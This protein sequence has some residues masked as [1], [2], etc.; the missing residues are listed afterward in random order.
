MKIIYKTR[1][2]FQLL[3]FNG[4]NLGEVKPS[5]P[6]TH[7]ECNWYRE[8]SYLN[9]NRTFVFRTELIRG[10]TMFLVEHENLT[11]VPELWGFSCC[12]V[13][14]AETKHCRNQICPCGL[15]VK[16]ENLRA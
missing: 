16:L 2:F 14:A 5:S 10:L 11:F 1:N 9:A 6:R 12:D 4:R 13:C 3:L 15:D 7:Q 8:E